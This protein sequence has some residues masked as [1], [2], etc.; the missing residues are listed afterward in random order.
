MAPVV[1]SAKGKGLPRLW[2]SE[3]ITGFWTCIFAK[4]FT[5]KKIQAEHLDKQLCAFAI[6]HGKTNAKCTGKAELEE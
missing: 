2:A 5:K 4:S 3:T 1:R 6:F